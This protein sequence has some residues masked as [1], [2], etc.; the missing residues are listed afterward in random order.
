MILCCL[1]G[2][3][4]YND[5]E[6]C[7]GDQRARRPEHL[8]N[9]GISW[10]P[11][12]DRL[13]LG[14]NVRLSRDASGCRRDE[15]DDYEVLDFNASF[16]GRPGLTFTAALKMYWMKTTRRFPLTIPV[17]RQATPA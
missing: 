2:N 8:A 11:L 17:G 7:D 5:T 6:N 12:R 10:S 15:L 3:Y 16:T 14:L 1:T 4:T 13:V 9:L